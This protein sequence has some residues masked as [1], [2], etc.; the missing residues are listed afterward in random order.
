MAKNEKP[1]P[2]TV[3]T[4][5]PIQDNSVPRVDVLLPPLEDEGADVALNQQEAVVINSRDYIIRR[6]ERV[7]VPY[8]VFIQL[9]NQFPNI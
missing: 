7:S 6:G 4:R 5:A 1:N 9:R 8:S 2:M 3:A